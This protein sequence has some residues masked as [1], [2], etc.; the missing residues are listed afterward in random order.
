MI[1]KFW[2]WLA[3]SPLST[4]VRVGIG[5]ALTFI[6]ENI[7]GFNLDPAVQVLVIAVVSTAL[8]WVNPLDG[9]YG[10]TAE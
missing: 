6:V 3:V 7:G 5:A 4:A 10:K 1:E 8:R 9:A 2:S